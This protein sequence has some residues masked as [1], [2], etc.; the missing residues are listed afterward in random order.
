MKELDLWTEVVGQPQA[1][2]NLRA[3]VSRPVHA[4]LL[5]GPRG[6]GKRAL[7]RAF[8]G[9]LLAH[10]LD[11]AD[12]HRLLDQVRREEHPDFHVIQR[13]GAA[14]SAEQATAVVR[15]ASRTPTEGDRK[16]IVLDEFHLL[17]DAV[18]P[19]LL[20]TIEEPPEGVV[21]LVLADELAPELVT[22][23]SR[24]VRVE[25][26]SVPFTDIVERL[27]FEGVPRAKADEAALGA[28][29]DLGRARVLATDP[30]LAFRRQ[31]WADVCLRLDGTGHRVSR[32]VD[33]IGAAID[34]AAAPLLAHQATEIAVLEERVA[35]FGERGSGRKDLEAR[36]K[37]ELR[38]HRTDE[39]RFGLAVL[40]RRYRDAVVT[41]ERPTPLYEA[42]AAIAATNE[43][44]ERNPVEKLALQAL[45]VR[46]PPI[47]V[48]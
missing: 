23:A 11:G 1:V 10:R 18:A 22:I 36:H 4:Y 32:Q 13:V 15:E 14:I 12:R 39:L 28:V 41:A 21:F 16:V 19:K 37:R 45:F 5:V 43:A 33:E 26:G 30:Q 3:A 31:L 24:C 20:K 25:L 48:E 44:L 17:A 8:G 27:I 34:N 38:R 46:L 47:S 7:A 2:A 35:Q 6:S 40:A 9:E 42:V 29:G